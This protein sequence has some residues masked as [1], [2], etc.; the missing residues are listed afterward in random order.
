VFFYTEPS[1]AEQRVSLVT[2]QQP[3]SSALQHTV[4]Y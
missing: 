3:M 4:L 1:T 2:A